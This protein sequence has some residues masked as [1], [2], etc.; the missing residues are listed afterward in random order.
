MRVD[1]F[2]F[3]FCK[4]KKKGRKGRERGNISKGNFS[5][6]FFGRGEGKSFPIFWTSP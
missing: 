6:S 1:I 5:I 2:F 3:F 4:K